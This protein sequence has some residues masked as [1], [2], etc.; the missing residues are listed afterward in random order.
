M[1]IRIE[2]ERYNIV[3][4]D[5][6]KRIRLKGQEQTYSEATELKDKRKDYE[7]VE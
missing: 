3:K 7:E 5:C 4:S 1:I 2:K 6:G